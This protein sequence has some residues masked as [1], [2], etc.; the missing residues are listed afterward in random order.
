MNAGSLS[1]SDLVAKSRSG[2]TQALRELLFANAGMINGVAA[3][4]TRNPQLTQ[5]IFQEV[6]MRVIR[7]IGDFKGHCKFSTWLY[8]ITV[9]VTFTVL[10]RETEHRKTTGLDD[11]PEQVLADDQAIEE[12]IDRR[13][14][15]EKAVT[16]IEGMPEI[17][18]EIFSMFYFADASLEDIA[19]QTGKSENAIKAILFKGRR[20]VTKQLK[21]SGMMEVL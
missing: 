20:L 1:E 7:K 12:S 4:I 2:D 3:R 17:S 6:A 13:R 15:F 10:A 14:M 19:K 16:I 8:R 21:K 18:R 5:D 11:V 9:N